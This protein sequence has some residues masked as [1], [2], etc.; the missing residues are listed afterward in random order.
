MPSVK[1]T[2]IHLDFGIF[3][4]VEWSGE[5][6]ADIYENRLELAEF[7]DKND[8]YA[9][10]LVEHHTTPLCIAP[11]PGIFLSAIAQRTSRIR[12]GPLGFLLPFHNP[13]RLYHEICMLDHLCQGRLELG[14]ARGVVSIEADRFGLPGDEERRDMMREALEVL[15]CGFNNETLDFEGKYY[16]YSGIKLWLKPYQKPYPPL[17]YPTAHID[18]IPWVA[19]SGMN[20]CGIIEPS[21]EYR[22]HYEL[23][24]KIWAEHKD[25][26]SRI[27]AHVAA[28]K[29]GMA[30]PVYVADTDDEALERARAAHAVWRSHIGFL[31]DQAGITIEP[32]ER[33]SDF[34]EQIREE[35]FIVGSPQTVAD[36]IERTVDDCG[37]NYFNAMFAFG[38]LT[39]QEVMRSVGRFASEV[40]P[41]FK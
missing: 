21:R 30:R 2:G 41:A 17:W 23:Y 13:L 3:D 40:M 5:R 4:S 8:F 37:I 19:E 34:D 27:N 31:F 1:P 36:K 32:L 22:E 39:H 18:M 35:T 29:I 26:P 25:D 24:K 7:A 10:H 16:S 38:D 6:A 20:T 28:P 15:L 33:L 9:F 14:F 11:S 12:I